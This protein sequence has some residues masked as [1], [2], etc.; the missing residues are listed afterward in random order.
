MVEL[1]QSFKDMPA[2]RAA[3]S[4]LSR[5]EG[6]IPSTLQDTREFML[7]SGFDSGA[8]T[9]RLQPLA[10]PGIKTNPFRARRLPRESTF[11]RYGKE[12]VKETGLSH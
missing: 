12:R 1:S 2:R 4:A 6:S 11:S 7:P 5:T 3:A 10:R 9:W 8:P